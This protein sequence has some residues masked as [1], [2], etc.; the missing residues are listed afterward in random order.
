[1]AWTYS[2]ALTL[3][4]DKVRF[5]IGDTDT[6]DQ[7]LSNEEIAGIIA[8]THGVYQAA[9]LCARGLESKYAR[10]ADKWVGD[11]KILASQKARR[12]ADL[13]DRLERGK[14]THQTPF[15]GGTSIAAKDTLEAD[16]DWPPMVFK[17]GMTDNEE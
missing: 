2:T 3:T 12:Y 15:A 11:L 17:V 1:M 7:Q 13:A 9:A 10:Q 4:R 6:N 14:R 16:T 8:L 5:L